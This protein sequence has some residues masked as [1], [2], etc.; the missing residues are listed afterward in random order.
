MDAAP[1]TPPPPVNIVSTR[2]PVAAPPARRR[3]RWLTPSLEKVFAPLLAC[4]IAVVVVYDLYVI[5]VGMQ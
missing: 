1:P 3:T 5:W 2:A 4:A